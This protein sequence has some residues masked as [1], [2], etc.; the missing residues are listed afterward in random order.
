[1]INQIP[2]VI[3]ISANGLAEAYYRS[4]KECIDKGALKKR[5]YGFTKD[6]VSI[7]EINDPLREPL[8][9]QDFPTRELHLQE[10][11]KQFE[12]GYDWRSQGFEYN[13][14]DRLVNYPITDISSRDDGYFK[15]PRRHY[16]KSIDQVQIIRERIAERIKKSEETVEECIVSNRDLIIT[17][18]PERDLFVSE[19]QP[20]LQSVQFFVYSYPRKVEGLGIVPGKGELHVTWRSR[21][22][23]GA[24]NSNLVAIIL[25]FKKEI[26]DPNNI[27]I[28]RVI[29]IC[30]SLHIYESDWEAASKVKPP[31]VNLYVS[32]LIYEE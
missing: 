1:M 23:Y 32:K 5:E 27:K 21:D 4:V 25:F 15:V 14:V 30:R 29:D 11:I 26:F 3:S 8:L 18:V 10:Y 17:W 7:I 2:P 19:D 31:N 24:W 9:H 22:L 12:K 13:Y 16:T 28:L 6:V 20:C